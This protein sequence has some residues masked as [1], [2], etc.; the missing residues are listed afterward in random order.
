MKSL[1]NRSPFRRRTPVEDAINDIRNLEVEF[2][3]GCMDD[4][5]RPEHIPQ[6]QETSAIEIVLETPIHSRS[7]SS[8]HNE[9][10]DSTPDLKTLSTTS[11]DSPTKPMTPPSSKRHLF[12]KKYMDP[13]PVAQR[14]LCGGLRSSNPEPKPRAMASPPRHVAAASPPRSRAASPLSRY[15][16]RSA[17][18]NSLLDDESRAEQLP[19]EH[20]PPAP[21][22]LSPTRP[23][24]LARLRSAEGGAGMEA[25]RMPSRLST[26]GEP[27]AIHVPSSNRSQI[28]DISHDIVP[29]PVSQLRKV[30]TRIES[31]LKSVKD[32]KVSRELVL[33]S[34]KRIADSLELKEDREQMHRE[35]SAWIDTQQ[36]EADQNHQEQVKDLVAKRQETETPPEEEYS[37][38]GSEDNM[39]REVHSGDYIFGH[40]HLGNN[41]SLDDETRSHTSVNSRG[42]SFTRWINELE[43]EST[44]GESNFFTSIM[45]F[46]S[47]FS[48]DEDDKDTAMEN[49]DW[50]NFEDT[51]AFPEAEPRRRE[52]TPSTTD[53]GAGSTSGEEESST[54]MGPQPPPPPPP[55]YH[56]APLPKSRD[57]G[58]SWQQKAD[59]KLKKRRGK[60]VL[61]RIASPRGASSDDEEDSLSMSSIEFTPPR[62]R[63]H[64][65]P[66]RSPYGRSARPKDPPAASPARLPPSLR[67]VRRSKSLPR[68]KAPDPSD[69]LLV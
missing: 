11:T 33:T 15:R 53:D 28:S 19:S 56:L 24:I 14:R 48:W 47:L 6:E 25:E 43:G 62:R 55:K 61:E 42:S 7:P 41:S 50:S 35:L 69:R 57:R 46:P 31:D 58:R 13:N 5:S 16:T 67:D 12:R 44:N 54:V 38:T 39:V 45:N 9:S 64:S 40:H 17:M 2:F 36:D 60:P 34:L 22:P 1:R 4:T 18:T 65:A 21:R 23:R 26:S 29:P 49:L 10:M 30:L 68:H 63:S 27:R 20:P 37:T 32:S 51:S 8:R 59:A 52:E 3:R 66:R